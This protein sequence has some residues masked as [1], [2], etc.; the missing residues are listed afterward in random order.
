M[1]KVK[2]KKQ[3]I[4]NNVDDSNNK[5]LLKDKTKTK[6]KTKESKTKKSK[7]ENDLNNLDDLDNLVEKEDNK[8]ENKENITYE[9]FKTKF[10]DNLSREI[11]EFSFINVIN[12]EWLC[13]FYK[14]DCQVY[15]KTENEYIERKK[16][17]KTILPEHDKLFNFTNFCDPENIVVVIEGQDPYHGLYYDHEQEEYIPEATGVCFSVPKGCPIPSS[18]KSIYRNMIKNNIINEMPDHGNLESWARQGILMINASLSV[19]KKSPNSHEKIWREFSKELMKS[20]CKINDDMIYVAWGKFAYNKLNE[21]IEGG[22]ENYEYKI[23][24]SHPSG[25]SANKPFKSPERDIMYCPFVD[26]NHFD[27]INKY[28]IKINKNTIDWNIPN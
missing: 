14:I 13:I 2:S 8:I 11:E 21:A 1:E 24:S 6:T 25:L 20:I 23:I 10:Y 27:K 16:T 19:E 28:L 3:T 7:K 22:I 4:I 9:M 26:I 5:K 12:K 17:K 15:E 18:L